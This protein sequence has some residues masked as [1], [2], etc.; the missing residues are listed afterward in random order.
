MSILSLPRHHLKHHGPVEAA[1][2][3]PAVHA[4]AAR[5]LSGM[6]RVDNEPLDYSDLRPRGRDVY[7]ADP[8]A[9]LFATLDEPAPATDW[10]YLLGAVESAELVA[11]SRL[12]T[13]ATRALDTIANVLMFATHQLY[14]DDAEQLDGAL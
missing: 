5:H 4:P 9:A 12:T 7:V 13:D 6:K 10:L 1:L 2:L 14:A 3:A 8:L 11:W